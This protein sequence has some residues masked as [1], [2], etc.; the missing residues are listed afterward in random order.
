VRGR[1]PRAVLDP[2]VDLLDT[3]SVDQLT[4]ASVLERSGV[5]YGSL[6]HHYEDLSDLIEQAAVECYS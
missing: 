5:A 6:Y 3:F 2:A 4:I 1:A